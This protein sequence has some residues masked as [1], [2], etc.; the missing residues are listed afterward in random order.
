MLPV[1]RSCTKVGTLGTDLSTCQVHIRTLVVPVLC[2]RGTATIMQ[3]PFLVTASDGGHY[4]HEYLL[5]R[6]VPLS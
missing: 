5:A 6:D 3:S 2:D 4:L 1:G